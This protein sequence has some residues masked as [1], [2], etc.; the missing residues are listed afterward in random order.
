MRSMTAVLLQ[1]STC[2][3][4]AT[5]GGRT[6]RM[7]DRNHHQ[8]RQVRGHPSGARVPPFA[9]VIANVIIGGKL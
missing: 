6:T 5:G 3:F 1:G 7:C 4:C 9:I 2:R 8:Q